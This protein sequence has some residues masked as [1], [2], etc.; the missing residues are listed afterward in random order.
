MKAR[1][2]FILFCILATEPC[3]PSMFISRSPGTNCTF[4]NAVKV[5][6]EALRLGNGI[7]GALV[8]GDGQPMKISFEV[9]FTTPR[10]QGEFLVSAERHEGVTRRVKIQAE[11][12]GG[13]RLLSPRS[14]RELVFA[15]KPGEKR[16][17]TGD[18]LNTKGSSPG[19]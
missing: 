13:C 11:K 16:T 4:T 14:G 6:D 18:P 10:T 8:W 15:M 17:L 3:S 5:W 12:S 7:L 1:A 19:K 2:V 9:E